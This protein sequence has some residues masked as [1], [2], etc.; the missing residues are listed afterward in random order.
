[1]LFR[2]LENRDVLCRISQA[3]CVLPTEDVCASDPESAAVR[4]LVQAQ[5]IALHIYV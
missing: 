4:A 5:F 2:A 1:M 3:R